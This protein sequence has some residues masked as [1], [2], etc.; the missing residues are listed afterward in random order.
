MESKK[1]QDDQ[2]SFINEKGMKINRIM[3]TEVPSNAEELNFFNERIEKIENLDDCKNL[4][5]PS[6]A[7]TSPQKSHQKDRKPRQPER[8]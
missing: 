3:K 1:E 4:K 6:K 5:V 7:I 2:P 8:P